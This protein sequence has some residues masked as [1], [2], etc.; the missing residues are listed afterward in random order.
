MLSNARSVTRKEKFISMAAVV[1]VITAQFEEASSYSVMVDK[2]NELNKYRGHRSCQRPGLGCC[3][4]TVLTVAMA[5][6]ELWPVDYDWL[7]VSQDVF[8]WLDRLFDRVLL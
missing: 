6:A 7:R 4:V 2:E 3:R 8:C 5:T 1:M